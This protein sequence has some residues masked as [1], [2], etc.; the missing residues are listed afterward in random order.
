[1]GGGYRN[2]LAGMQLI[3]LTGIGKG[4]NYPTDIDALFEIGDKARIIYEFK[5]GDADCSYGQRLALT[6]LVDDFEAIG[7]HSCLL[8]A[9]H[10]TESPAMVAGAECRV[11][12]VYIH[13]Q[14][15]E[16]KSHITVGEYT[17]YLRQKW[18][19]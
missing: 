11:D 17:K 13:K 15:H 4:N 5:Y 2:P 14:W 3:D 18:G 9:H 19:V 10:K 8:I 16:I 7:K 1:M 6:R 12:K